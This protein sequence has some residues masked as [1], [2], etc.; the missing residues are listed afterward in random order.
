VS[1]HLAKEVNSPSSFPNNI[2]PNNPTSKTLIS[3]RAPNLRKTGVF[4]VVFFLFF[5]FVRGV[6]WGKKGKKGGGG[7]GIFF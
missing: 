7:G 5:V 3:S 4:G 6:F 2:K 1:D